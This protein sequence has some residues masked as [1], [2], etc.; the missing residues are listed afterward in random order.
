MLWPQLGGGDV[1]DPTQRVLAMS[2]N[3]AVMKHDRPVAISGGRDDPEHY[4][5]LADVLA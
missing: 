4:L 3:P 2:R 5:L 1:L